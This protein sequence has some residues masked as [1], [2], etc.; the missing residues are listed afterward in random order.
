MRIRAGL[1]SEEWFDSYEKN[2][3]QNVQIRMHPCPSE[4]Y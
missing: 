1:F 2:K 4:A 3:N